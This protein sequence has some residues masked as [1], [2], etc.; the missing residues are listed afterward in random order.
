MEQSVQTWTNEA[1]S[2]SSPALPTGR[3][4]AIEGDLGGLAA[5]AEELDGVEA[6]LG[7]I[8]A[9]T[10]GRCTRCGEVIDPAALEVDPLV[11]VCGPHP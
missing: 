11:L 1:T 8:D 10:Y 6:A 5:V 9:G 7:R 3:R 4:A 2:G